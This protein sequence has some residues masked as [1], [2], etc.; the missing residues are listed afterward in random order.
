VALV[1]K[2]TT[3]TRVMEIRDKVEG[4]IRGLASAVNAA[5]MYGSGHKMAVETID[6]LYV[7]LTDALADIECI[8]IGVIGE[9]IAFGRSPFCETSKKVKGLVSRL[10]RLEIEKITFLSG[11]SKEELALF[12]GIIGRRT[13]AE[14]IKDF[15]EK[16]VSPSIRIG[17]IG[18]SEKSEDG[19]PS[20][21]DKDLKDIISQVYEDGTE[22]LKK[23]SESLKSKGTID[24]GS[25]RYLVGGIVN[26]LFRNMDLLR[27]M[28]SVKSHDESTY[29][30]EVNVA[31][32]TILQAESLGIEENGLAEIGVAALLH[33]VG[34][35]AV[36]GDVIRKE[37]QLTEE[38]KASFA[39]HPLD[40]AKILLD[41]P[42][43]GILAAVTAFEHHM[44]YDM[45]GYPEKKYGKG[46]S[47]VTM[48]VTIADVYDALRSE[49]SYHEGAA[50]EKVYRDMMEL[51]GGLF[52][53]GLLDNFFRVIGMYPPG[54]IVELDTGEIGIVVKENREDITRP[55]VEIL[56]GQSGEKLEN[57][58]VADLSE[59]N[60]E[61]KYIKSISRS[62]APSDGYG[63]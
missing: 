36:T 19:S 51:S 15:F 32:F 22:F 26:S 14:D 21:A 18:L 33:D 40:G 20:S 8:T 25:A 11:I 38:D 30:H 56:Y 59:K 16:G 4:V 13:A 47:L 44:R 43:A 41:T 42:G 37:E 54:S 7:F 2:G 9:E 35:L 3:G 5:D 17:K 46:T 28:T 52:H 23:T 50:P 58:Y 31:I 49:R 61:G 45:S 57:I 10:K 12:V 53:P 39:A 1:K 55:R 48:M 34:K 27:V 6:G 60:G 63:K 62:V 24:G 29:L